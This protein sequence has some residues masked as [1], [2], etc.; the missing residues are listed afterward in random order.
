MRAVVYFS[1]TGES[2][3]IAAY[4]AKKTGFPLRALEECK[5]TAFERLILV[6]PIYCQNAPAPVCDFLRR[7]KSEGFTAVA[8]YG[9]MC[10]GNVLKELQQK[11]GAQHAL[12]AAAYLPTKHT[13]LEEESFLALERLQPLVENQWSDQKVEIPRSYKN[14]LANFAMGWRS[15][16]GIKIVKNNRCI[17]CGLCERECVYKAMQKGK[18]N[19]KCVR[20]LRCVARCPVQAL[21]F[22]CRAPLKWYLKKKKKDD[23]VLYIPTHVCVEI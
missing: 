19:Q 18:P 2:K 17:G 13:Y 14:P 11:Y 5:E 20:C 21:T 3:K 6:F 22:T 23:L 9:R 7:T 4:L 15:R 8:S 10:H 1:N 12:I 16:I